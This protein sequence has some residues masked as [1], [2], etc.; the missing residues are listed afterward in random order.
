[1][2]GF[3]KDLMGVG[4]PSQV[5][6]AL[7]GSYALGKTATGSTNADA[8]ALTAATTEFTT[9]AAS[10]GA[11]LPSTSGRVLLGDQLLVCNM[12]ANTLKVYPPVGYKINA[13][14]TDAAVSISTLKTA[15]FFPKGD[16]NYWAILSA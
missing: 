7:G 16:G 4:L 11:I 6:Q 8:Y 5:A 10:T 12:G 1:M 3:Q 14:T 2:I 9:T 13:G 15:I